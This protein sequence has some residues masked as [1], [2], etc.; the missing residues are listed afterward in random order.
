MLPLHISPNAVRPT[1]WEEELSQVVLDL[2]I[3]GLL[4]EGQF[5]REEETSQVSRPGCR[6]HFSKQTGSDATRGSECGL[7]TNGH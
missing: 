6:W 4:A 1:L 7:S 3:D 2:Q 5:S